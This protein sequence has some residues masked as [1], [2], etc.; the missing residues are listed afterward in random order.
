[1]ILQNLIGTI[2]AP[3]Q[4]GGTGYAANV[5]SGG[6]V[7]IIDNLARFII[8]IGGIWAFANVI[9]AGFAYIQQGDQPEKLQ[10]AHQRLTMSLIGLVLMIGS[11]VLAGIIS[12]ILY[13]N[14]ATILSPIIYGPA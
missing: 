4:F 13:G 8:I 6:L 10:Q 9:L 2:N 11:F 3:P 14:A 7:S 5:A 12:Y 1:M